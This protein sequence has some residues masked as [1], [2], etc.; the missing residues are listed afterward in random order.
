MKE[1]QGKLA[2]AQQVSKRAAEEAK[3]KARELKTAVGLARTI[4]PHVPVWVTHRGIGAFCPSD[5]GK[6]NGENKATEE[7]K[8]K[9]AGCEEEKQSD[10]LP[11]EISNTVG[12]LHVDEEKKTDKEVQ[13]IE[14]G[15]TTSAE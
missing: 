2:A 14:D 3:Q 1:A 12:R 10:A 7:P 8:V 15:E 6:S 13:G 4:G 9:S 11:T 5:F